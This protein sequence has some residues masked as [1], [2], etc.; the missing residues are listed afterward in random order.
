[1]LS[2]GCENLLALYKEMQPEPN[3]KAELE[4][5]LVK[6]RESHPIGMFVNVNLTG[7]IGFV[8]S[9]NER[10]GGFYPGVRY[11]VNVDIVYS[12]LDKAVGCTFEYSA[13]QLLPVDMYE[14]AY[15]D[16]LNKK[17]PRFDSEEYMRHYNEWCAFC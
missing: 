12:D 7:H 14:L 8:T 9:Y 10:L 2:D 4:K 5:L 3:E 15:H 11:P 17:E 1:M 6:V 16:V 13:D